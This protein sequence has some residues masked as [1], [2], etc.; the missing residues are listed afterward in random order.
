[1]A[2][3][4]CTCGEGKRTVLY[5]CSDVSN[6][7]QLANAATVRL[8]QEGKGRIG[9]LA[10]IGSQQKRFIAAAKAADEVVAIDGC[11]VACVKKTLELAGIIPDRHIM[12]TYFGITKSGDL[13]LH[14]E[15]S[16]RVVGAVAT[17]RKQPPTG[18]LNEKSSEGGCGCGG[19][20]NCG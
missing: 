15:E 5:G 18:D 19:G 1:M 7:G 10:G 16:E 17:D 11:E 3:T 4:S 12:V 8:T 14:D 9:C 2:E 6:T 13:T 20:C